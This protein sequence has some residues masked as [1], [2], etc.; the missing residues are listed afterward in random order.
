MIILELLWS[1]MKVGFTSFSGMSMVPLI[2]SEMVGHGWMTLAEVTDI[3]A[4]AEMTP[5]PLGFNC[6]TFAGFRTAGILG[7]AAA[8]L[9]V[10]TPT[11]T[12][13]ALAA[14][15]YERFSRSK[16]M[17]KML[18]VIR[19][20]CIGLIIGMVVTL[21]R[22]NYLKPAGIHFPSVLLGLVDFYLLYKRKF[23]VPKI[24]IF[25]AA[26]GLICFGFLK[27]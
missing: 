9:G 13:G 2:S 11:I 4:I 21:S 1:F 19:P 17:Q 16:Y 22:T 18:T 12:V 6:A 10:L 15:F 8:N 20:A 26:V 7:A 27:L 24:I 25:S 3:V 23:S 5:G 14:K